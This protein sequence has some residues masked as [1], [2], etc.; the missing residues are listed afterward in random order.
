MPSSFNSADLFN[1]GPHR[2]HVGPRGDQLIEHT[3]LDPTS[4]GR[5]A[6]GP[7]DAVVTVRGRLVAG[8][9]EDLWTLI[10]NI[11]D[12]LNDP[13]TTA[14]LV[15]SHDHTFKDM[16]FISFTPLSPF[17]RG[18]DVSVPYEALFTHFGG[19]K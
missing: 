13:P 4:P 3:V 6:I 10:K 16:S 5:Q 8:S 18:R 17:E 11:E 15:D 1:S 9:D 19:W 2:F 7:L 12:Q 14:D